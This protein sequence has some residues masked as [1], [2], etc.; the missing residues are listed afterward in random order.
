MFWISALMRASTPPVVSWACPPTAM[1]ISSE[2]GQRKER[3][4]RT[5]GEGSRSRDLDPQAGEHLSQLGHRGRGT[6]RRVTG[7]SGREPVDAGRNRSHRAAE[8]DSRP[9]ELG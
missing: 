7:G 1:V 4:E 5:T 3:A 8:G 2:W 6:S 9:H